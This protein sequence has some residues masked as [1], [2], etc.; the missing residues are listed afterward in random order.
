M[1]AFFFFEIGLG[2][3]NSGRKPDRSVFG[4]INPVTLYQADQGLREL[5]RFPVKKAGWHYHG[6]ANMVQH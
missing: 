3:D 2:F 5:E 4:V 1:A 6:L